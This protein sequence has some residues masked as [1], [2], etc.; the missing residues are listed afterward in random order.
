MSF[1]GNGQDMHSSG[2]NEALGGEIDAYLEIIRS[3]QVQVWADE[4]PN[5]AG[6]WLKTLPLGSIRD[7]ALAAYAYVEQIAPAFPEEARRWAEH[8]T[9]ISP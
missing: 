8:G 5:D 1:E 3:Y 6:E 2:R 7:H 4:N 9:S